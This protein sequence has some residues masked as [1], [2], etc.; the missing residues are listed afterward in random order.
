MV[1]T[2]L[3][4]DVADMT[5]SVRRFRFIVDSVISFM[6]AN[7]VAYITNVLF[8]FETGRHSRWKE[9]SLFY[10]VSGLAFFIAVGLAAALIQYLGLSTTVAKLSNIV[11]A[12][13]INYALRRFFIFKG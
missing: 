13:L 8:V 9:I 4:L 12:V 1:V 2:L 6:F 3:G 5:D 11:T 7:F 10:A